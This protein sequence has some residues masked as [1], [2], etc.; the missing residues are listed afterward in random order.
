M[1]LPKRNEKDEL[2]NKVNVL[3]NRVDE[4]FNVLTASDKKFVHE[5][6]NNCFNLVTRRSVRRDSGY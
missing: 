3:A 2:L 4:K 6:L 1:N 5:Q